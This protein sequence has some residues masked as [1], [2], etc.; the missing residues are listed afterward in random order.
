MSWLISIETLPV[1]ICA[2]TGHTAT[3]GLAAAKRT[4]ATV[5][6]DSNM[7]VVQM[8]DHTE[9]LKNDMK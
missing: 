5:F 2:G 7:T 1:V 9:E 6:G 8:G 4:A 3:T